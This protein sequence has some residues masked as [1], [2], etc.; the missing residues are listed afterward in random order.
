MLMDNSGAR[1]ANGEKEQAQFGGERLAENFDSLNENADSGEQN[2]VDARA[3]DNPETQRMRSELQEM[4]GKKEEATEATDKIGEAEV[5][6][7]KPEFEKLSNIDV[8][9]DAERIPGSFSNE[10]QRII[11]HALSHDKDSYLAA[12]ELYEMRWIYLE[13]AYGRKI[14]DGL[15]NIT[16]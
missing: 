15:L 14:G 1:E 6:P 7:V 3:N 9:R 5:E 16:K 4:F 10:A 11:D 8:P 2:A 12:E 13:K